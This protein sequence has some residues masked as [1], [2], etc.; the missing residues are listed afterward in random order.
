MTTNEIRA[1]YDRNI[2]RPCKNSNESREESELMK[3]E[4]APEFIDGESRFYSGNFLS[5]RELKENTIFFKHL[6]GENGEFPFFSGMRL[7]FSGETGSIFEKE[8]FIVKFP[9]PEDGTDYCRIIEHEAFV[10]TALNSLREEIPNFV[11]TYHFGNSVYPLLE[12]TKKKVLPFYSNGEIPFIIFEKV[13]GQELNAILSTISLKDFQNV[14]IQCVMALSMALERMEFTHFDLNDKNIIVKECDEIKIDYSIFGKKY[15]ITSSFIPVILDFGASFVTKNGK[16]YGF[17]GS[18]RMECYGIL[19]Q[20][21]PLSD[22][23]KLLCYCGKRISKNNLTVYNYIKKL[24]LFFNDV[25]GLSTI[26]E[27]QSKYSYFYPPTDKKLEDFID[28][29]LSISEIQT[30]FSSAEDYRSLDD[31]REISRSTSPPASPESLRK[32][33][34]RPLIRPTILTFESVN[35]NSNFS[36]WMANCIDFLKSYYISGKPRQ[37]E[38]KYL[39]IIEDIKTFYFIV[40]RDGKFTLNEIKGDSQRSEYYWRLVDFRSFG[41]LFQ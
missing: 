20:P 31:G 36:K 24:V 2:T 29:C 15:S 10:G 6:F 3:T 34:S 7:I 41:G 38:E 9:S 35:I 27:R 37:F 14:F 19:Q 23:Y 16:S 32:N 4:Y 1:F 40:L 8:D 18:R 21:N 5:L 39:K 25:E 11:Y 12:R 17:P 30:L 33:L 28:Y 22:I 13:R 26:I